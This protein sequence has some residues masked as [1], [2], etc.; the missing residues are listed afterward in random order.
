M[1]CKGQGIE[2]TESIE[3]VIKRNKNLVL[4]FCMPAMLLKYPAFIACLP[5]IRNCPENNLNVCGYG[6]IEPVYFFHL[7]YLI[8]SSLSTKISIRKVFCRFSTKNILY[9]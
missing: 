2:N 7:Q 1:E 3:T 5:D 8:K 9:W 4:Y 6:Y